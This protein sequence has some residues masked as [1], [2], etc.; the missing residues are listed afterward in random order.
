MTPCPPQRGQL[1]PLRPNAR[2]RHVRHP[3][4]AWLREQRL[5]R[6]WT[7]AEMGRQAPA[8]PPGPPDDRTVPGRR[9]HG[10]LRSSLGE[11]ASAALSERYRLHY[12]A[13]LGILPRTCSARNCAA[14]RPELAS[15][16]AETASGR[17]RCVSSGRTRMCGPAPTLPR[18]GWQSNALRAETV[19]RIENTV[20][21]NRP[22]SSS[23]AW[24]IRLRS[25]DG[26]DRA[27]VA[28]LRG[29]G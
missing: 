2:N 16:S 27:R 25:P 18:S 8:R 28:G 12:C 21:R 14:P 19:I 15:A 10:L 1:T 17:R 23:A 20:S 5:A 29:V 11:P 4:S 9:D 7:A 6:G 24:Q 13:A 26:H 22:D 3:R